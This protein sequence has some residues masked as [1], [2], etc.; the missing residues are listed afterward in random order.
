[1]KVLI[2]IPMLYN[3]HV[4]RECLDSILG[5][6]DIDIL[7]FDNGAEPEV[8]DT[9]RQYQ[10]DHQNIIVLSESENIYV[11]PA[12]NE[13]MHFFLNQPQ[14]EYCIILNSDVIMNVSW[15][16]IL[17]ACVKSI[18]EDVIIPTITTNKNFVHEPQWIKES[19][20]DSIQIKGGVPGVCIGLHRKQVELV[21]PIPKAI[22]VWFGDNYIFG[23]LLGVGYN[24]YMPEPFIA[25]H[26][27][28][29]T[30]KRVE[31]IT[32]IIE[33][34]K[35]AWYTL[36]EPIMHEKIKLHNLKKDL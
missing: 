27:G 28:S 26:H 1:M 2:G 24:I 9:I 35:H 15:W 20:F 21:Y 36:V 31:G 7:C 18:P 33:Q 6:P 8:K 12:W 29:E 30:V 3:A 17:N 5:R 19:G 11:N 16:N 22:K 25:F 23:L 13:I 4:I 34:D 14:Y 32:E 10:A